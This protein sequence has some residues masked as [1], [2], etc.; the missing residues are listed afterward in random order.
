MAKYPNLKLVFEI[1]ERMCE[2]QH[3][4]RFSIF[5]A[6]DSF[7]SFEK[8]Y[9]AYNKIQQEGSDEKKQPTETQKK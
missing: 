1:V 4:K 2:F 5:D 6:C 8:M 7:N 3:K 9:I